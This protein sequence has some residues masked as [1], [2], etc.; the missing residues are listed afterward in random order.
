M[1]LKEVYELLYKELGPQH[2]WPGESRLEIC[3]GAILTQNTAWSNVE[4]A[5]DNLGEK[6]YLNISDLLAVKISRLKEMIKP[7]G[8]YNRKSETIKRFLN[9]LTTDYSKNFEKMNKAHPEHLREDLLSIKGIG[10]E[11]ADSMLLYAFEKKYFVIDAY[12]RRILS[13]HEFPVDD[14]SYETLRNY[15][16][17]RIPEDLQ[18][19]N[20]FHALLV[21]IGKNYC[22][23]SSPDCPACPLEIDL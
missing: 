16:E 4:L 10:P 22:S 1:K 11:T 12:T 14:M 18:L 8:Y 13:R 3:L 5:I 21:N 2:W 15:M 6:D 9:L 17:D 19:Y 23:F 20:E 7:A